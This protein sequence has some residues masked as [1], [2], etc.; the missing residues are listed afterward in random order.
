MGSVLRC[1]KL[2]KVVKLFQISVL[3]QLLKDGR[4]I[5]IEAV[6]PHLFQFTVARGKYRYHAVFKISAHDITAWKEDE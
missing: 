4:I 6:D 1:L 3:P 2:V 5:D